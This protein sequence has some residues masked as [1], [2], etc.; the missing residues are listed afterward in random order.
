MADLWRPSADRELSRLNLRLF[1]LAYAS[2]LAPWLHKVVLGND[3]VERR[4]K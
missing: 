1:G 2:G 4:L 3:K